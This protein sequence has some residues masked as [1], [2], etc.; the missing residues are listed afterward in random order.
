[1]GCSVD[2]VLCFLQQILS[3]FIALPMPDDSCSGGEIIWAR[4]H[5]NVTSGWPVVIWGTANWCMDPSKKLFWDGTPD[6][7]GNTSFLW[8][9]ICDVIN[10]TPYYTAWFLRRA[11][12]F[13]EG[14]STFALVNARYSPTRPSFAVNIFQKTCHLWM[15]SQGQR[16]L[17]SW[18]LPPFEGKNNRD[19]WQKPRDA[20]TGSQMLWVC[21]GVWTWGVPP[22]GYM[23]ILKIMQDLDEP[24]NFQ[25]HPCMDLPRT[26]ANCQY[27]IYMEHMGMVN[28]IWVQEYPLQNC[29]LH[30]FY[31]SQGYCHWRCESLC[32]RIS[33]LRRRLHRLALWE[34]L[35]S[36]R[37]IY[38]HQFRWFFQR[39]WPWI[40]KWLS[41]Q[42]AAYQSYHQLLGPQPISFTLIDVTGRFGNWPRLKEPQEDNRFCKPTA[43]C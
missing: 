2:A 20:T 24:F 22:A 15:L 4:P 16:C 17:R 5:S 28:S 38:H 35:G 32:A 26:W 40:D 36:N 3:L 29:C 27:M 18:I 13:W 25:T 42:P 31:K 37:A 41:H 8:P 39:R 43:H 21:Q 34:T 1:M 14:I 33:L 30:K 12:S 9:Q 19:W 6:N 7:I 11:I 10:V 23:F